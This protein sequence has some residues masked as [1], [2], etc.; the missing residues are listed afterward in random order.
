MQR[1]IDYLAFCLLTAILVLG[2]LCQAAFG[3]WA[4]LPN[5]QSNLNISNVIWNYT[6]GTFNEPAAYVAVRIDNALFN[7]GQINI[8]GYSSSYISMGTVPFYL[9]Q[10]NGTNSVILLPKST[11][12]GNWNTATI[13]FNP[14]AG[15]APNR[16]LPSANLFVN[17]YKGQTVTMFN[18]NLSNTRNASMTTYYSGS[19]SLNF[20]FTM[21][22]IYA[23]MP[24]YGFV[25]LSNNSLQTRT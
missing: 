13:F 14:I 23:G 10:F 16:E 4:P 21:D 15:S 24:G 25:L 11:L 8:T 12:K 1:M 6:S 22:T 5:F 3:A 18:L 19:N 7:P 20:N 9:L 2:L 17:T